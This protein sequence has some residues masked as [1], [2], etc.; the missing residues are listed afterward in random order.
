MANYYQVLKVTQ[1]ASQR[2]I[3]SAYRRLARK[4][5]P[6]VNSSSPA[7]QE[8]FA[9][10]AKA[11][12]VLGDPKLRQVY[13][14]QINGSVNGSN[15]DSVVTSQNKH[16]QRLRRMAIER[17]LNAF[18]DGLIAE[19]RRENIAMQRMIFPV[20]TLLVST[21]FVAF[22]KPMFWENSLTI[23]RILIVTLFAAGTVHMISRLYSG[24]Q[25]YTYEDAEIHE[26]ILEA[27]E[28][29][30]KPFPRIA[31]VFLL[32][33]GVALSF[34]LGAAVASQMDTMIVNMRVSLFSASLSPT[35]IFYPPIAVLIVDITHSIA[36][37]KQLSQ[38]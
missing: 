34:A 35:L 6:D 26:S 1:R 7:A 21:F 8:E 10:L 30:D 12:E 20:V 9:R 31:A 13:D 33:V 28:S 37:N 11:Y 15:G 29:E 22:F 18:V 36:L 2:E 23:G 27:V 14:R 17:K 16:A 3:K 32:C 25:K 5:H 24:F 38:P 19:Q 4:V